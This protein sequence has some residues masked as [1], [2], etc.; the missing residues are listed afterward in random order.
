MTNLITADKPD[1]NALLPAKVTETNY[2][3]YIRL[4]PA[5]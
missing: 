5:G 2:R 3:G 4:K 1:T